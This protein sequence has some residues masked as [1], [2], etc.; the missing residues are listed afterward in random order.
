MRFWGGHTGHNSAIKMDFFNLEA[1]CS[2]S[3]LP[4][5]L[6]TLPMDTQQIEDSHL[7][8][9]TSISAIVEVDDAEPKEERGTKHSCHFKPASSRI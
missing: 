1:C 2:G 4:D 6:Q 3:V 7:F 5:N 8:R 9:A